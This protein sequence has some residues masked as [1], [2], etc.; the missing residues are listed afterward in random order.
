M[1]GAEVIA[2][3]QLESVKASQR[4]KAELFPKVGS[5]DW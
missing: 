2:A 4:S 3:S 5:M 1:V